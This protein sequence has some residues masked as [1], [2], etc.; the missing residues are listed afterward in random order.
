ML[1]RRNNN[2]NKKNNNNNE[3]TKRDNNIGSEVTTF[4]EEFKPRYSGERPRGFPPPLLKLSSNCQTSV[5]SHA[6]T[7]ARGGRCLRRALV[8]ISWGE[9]QHICNKNT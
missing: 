2:N 5:I 8:A 6:L 4:T 3:G 1:M 9:G 7:H